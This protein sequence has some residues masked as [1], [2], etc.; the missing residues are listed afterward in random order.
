MCIQTRYVSKVDGLMVEVKMLSQWSIY[1]VSG[2]RTG[3]GSK[4]KL[5][6][7]VSKGE[8]GKSMECQ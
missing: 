1:V 2:G 5:L 8:G 4:G 3:H 7:S 6:M